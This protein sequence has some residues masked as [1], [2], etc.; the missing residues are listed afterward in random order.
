M[1]LFSCATVSF[2]SQ[3]NESLPRMWW[4]LSFITPDALLHDCWCF[5]SPRGLPNNFQLTYLPAAIFAPTPML[6]KMFLLSSISITSADLEF[7]Q[8]GQ[9]QRLSRPSFEH[10]R[11]WVKFRPL[12]VC[13]SFLES[14]WSCLMVNWPG[15][16]KTALWNLWAPLHLRIFPISWK[17]TQLNCFQPS[18]DNRV[19]GT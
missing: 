18:T 1:F 5:C 14:R 13:M 19:S 16:S 9:S 17:C 3:L 6:S 10:I 2:L 7:H 8:T 15:S 11:L 4:S 12:L